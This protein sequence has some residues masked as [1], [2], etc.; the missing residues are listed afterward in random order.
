MENLVSSL[1]M[2]NLESSLIVENL[3]G[4]HTQRK[5]KLGTVF[6]LQLSFDKVSI[7]GMAANKMFGLVW[8]VLRFC[9]IDFF[10]CISSNILK[11][12]VEQVSTTKINTNVIWDSG[13]LHKIILSE[14]QTTHIK[15]VLLTLNT[16]AQMVTVARLSVCVCVCVCVCYIH[17][18]ASSHVPTSVSTMSRGYSSVSVRWDK[19]GGLAHYF[20]MAFYWAQI[21]LWAHLQAPLVVGYVVG[22][23]ASEG[24][25]T[26][27]YWM[28]SLWCV[29]S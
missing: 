24:Y 10:I 5:P 8:W 14:W 15:N 6:F 17:H 29:G 28:C 22:T 20:S 3:A 12:F 27:W 13:V 9:C 4:S 11:I 25:A 21:I 7:V 16:H 2:E 1:I 23:T 19:C 26:G 18:S